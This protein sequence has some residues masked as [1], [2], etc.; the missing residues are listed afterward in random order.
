[1]GWDS[2]T[3]VLNSV[4]DKHNDGSSPIRLR[5]V[6][7]ISVDKR[8]KKPSAGFARLGLDQWGVVGRP[9]WRQLN[10]PNRLYRHATYAVT[11]PGPTHAL[12]TQRYMMLVEGLHEAQARV[13]IEKAIVAKRLVFDGPVKDLLLFRSAFQ[14]QNLAESDPLKH[15]PPAN[16]IDQRAKLFDVA[17]VK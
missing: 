16:W 15:F 11:R 1:M 12:P 10:A 14:K 3:L 6:I 4:R 13:A 8:H 5:Q 9:E 7:D 17:D 2:K